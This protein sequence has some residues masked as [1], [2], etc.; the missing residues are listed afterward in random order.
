MD[1]HGYPWISM[2]IHGY[3]WIS[4]DIYGYPW[5]PM[6]THGYPLISMDIHGYPWMY[7]DI[8]FTK[9]ERVAQHAGFNRASTPDTSTRTPCFWD[10]GFTTSRLVKRTRT[11]R[12][13]HCD[14]NFSRSHTEVWGQ[15][16]ANP[17]ISMDTHGYPWISMDIHGYPWIS[18]DIHG[19]P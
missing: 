18:M 10:T 19:Y 14:L 9:T 16:N 3:P 13:C 17:W 12:R 2:D 15:Q 8:H 11:N 7:M 4:M 5:I 6:E 1:T